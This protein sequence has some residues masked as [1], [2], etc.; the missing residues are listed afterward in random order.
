MSKKRKNIIKRLE[1][2]TYK[3]EELEYEYKYIK[4]NLIQTYIN[5]QIIYISRKNIQEYIN[6]NKFFMYNVD[7]VINQYRRKNRHE[8]IDII[9]N[10]IINDCKK[11]INIIL[12]LE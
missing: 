9:A 12:L 1:K 11:Y 6:I 7:E 10:Q 4:N 2:L 3:I 8:D 5:N